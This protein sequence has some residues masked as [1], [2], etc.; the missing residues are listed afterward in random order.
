MNK[1]GS[2]RIKIKKISINTKKQD[3][4]FKCRNIIIKLI[5]SNLNKIYINKNKMFK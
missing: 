5:D 2:Q 3:K 1:K 4:S